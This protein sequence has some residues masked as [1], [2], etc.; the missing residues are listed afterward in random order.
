MKVVREITPRPSSSDVI[1]LKK[2]YDN[3]FLL[4]RIYQE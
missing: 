2:K 4:E 3:E 1:P